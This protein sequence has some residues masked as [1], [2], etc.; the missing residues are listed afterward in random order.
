MEKRLISITHATAGTPRQKSPIS[1]PRIFPSSS[2]L[3]ASHIKEYQQG[4]ESIP[5]E[6]QYYIQPE[7]VQ[8]DIPSELLGGSLA[9][10][11]P[12]LTK[13]YGSRV[14]NPS[15]GDGMVWTLALSPSSEKEEA[16]G[17]SRIFF[18]NK[19]VRTSSFN[20]EQA[21]NTLLLPPPIA[22]GYSFTDENMRYT[23]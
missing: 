23:V 5:Y 13:A 15:D 21:S 2:H 3:S 20:A 10:I 4:Y 17:S 6:Y 11:G 1:P 8:G 18:R 7:W 16:S 19:F 9:G 22:L 14:R 12:G